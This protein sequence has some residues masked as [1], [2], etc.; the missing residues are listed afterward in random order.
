MSTVVDTR[1]SRAA[2]WL[3]VAS[4]MR[5]R[6]EL[7]EEQERTLREAMRRVV[8][9]SWHSEARRIATE[10]LAECDKLAAEHVAKGAA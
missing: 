8:I 3:D 5:L 1:E 7:A 10:A 9:S 6:A 4:R 2:H